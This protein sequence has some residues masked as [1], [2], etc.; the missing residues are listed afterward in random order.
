MKGKKKNNGKH[1]HMI[2]ENPLLGYGSIALSVCRLGYTHAKCTNAKHH[3][4]KSQTKSLN[5]TKTI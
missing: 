1:F 3:L 2:L 5:T 4:Q